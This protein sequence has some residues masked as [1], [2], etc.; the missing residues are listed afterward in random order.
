MKR[1]EELYADLKKFSDFDANSENPELFLNTVD[2]IVLRNDPSSI[3]VLLKYLDDNSEHTWVMESLMIALENYEDKTYVATILK[4]LNETSPY[5]MSGLIFG[6]LNNNNCLSLFKKG[7]I[8]ANPTILL[9]LFDFMKNKSTHH[10]L[11]IQELR[12][13][14]EQKKQ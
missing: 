11:L 9:K 4:N 13:E 5:W 10:A 14:L 2:E 1:L 12:H 8:L 3:A 6:I 7:L